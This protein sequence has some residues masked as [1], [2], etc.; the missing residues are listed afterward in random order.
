MYTHRRT[1][2]HRHM[3]T[4]TKHTGMLAKVSTEANVSRSIHTHKQTQSHKLIDI[5]THM[6]THGHPE[7][8]VFL[9]LSF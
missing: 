9:A 6:H 5:C 2:T 4:W 8:P 7:E 3:D 1:D